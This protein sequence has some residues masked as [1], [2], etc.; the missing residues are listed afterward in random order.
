M[1]P[2]QY[3]AFIAE[4]RRLTPGKVR[5]QDIARLLGVSIDTH[6]RMKQRGAVTH[7][8]VFRLAIASILHRLEPYGED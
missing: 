3:N 1:T 2:D 4:Y 5:D 6:T 7:G 8:K